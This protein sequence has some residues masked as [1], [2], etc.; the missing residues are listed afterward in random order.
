MK[1]SE[2]IAAHRNLS[3]LI[4]KEEKYPVK[5]SYAITRNFKLLEPLAKDY[6]EELNKL[7]DQYNVKNDSGEPAYKDSGEIK[8]AVEYEELWEV[9]LRELLE[10]DVEFTPHTIPVE[11]LPGTIEP[12]VLYCLD[13][14]INE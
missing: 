11:H 8:I 9:S 6:Q 2:I 7:L 4:G 13:F 3:E 14:M 10:I 1:N 5:F 12:G